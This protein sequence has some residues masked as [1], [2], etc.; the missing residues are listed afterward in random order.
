MYRVAEN[1]AE[2]LRKANTIK[3]EFLGLVSHELRTPIATVMGNGLLLLNRGDLLQ[4]ED[5]R[6]ALGDLVG[7]ARRLGRIVENVLLLTRAEFG[8]P[9][10]EPLSLQHAIEDASRAFRERNSQRTLITHFDD[11]V[12][13]ADAEPALIVLVL[14]NL[15]SNAD[16]Y[17]PA[18]AEIE[19][20]LYANECGQPEVC[21]RDH[22]IGL[23]EEA[24]QNLFTPFFR[25]QAAKRKAGGMGLGLAVCR[26]VVQAHGG[27]IRA[28]NHPGGG[29]E[30]CFSLEAA[31]E[32]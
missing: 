1:A 26:R 8:P 3:D 5:R 16:K 30:F 13:A 9:Q 29:A 20:S 15:L 23:D 4:P 12:P 11:E 19:V 31:P 18:D 25:A 27:E 22:G 6:Q 10:R 7:E 28:G 2:N 32:T 17:S 24:L 14:E 21:V